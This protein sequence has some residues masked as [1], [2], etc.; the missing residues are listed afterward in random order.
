MQKRTFRLLLLV[1]LL[2]IISCSKDKSTNPSNSEVVVPLTIGNEW[3]YVELD[4]DLNIEEWSKQSVIENRTINLNNQDIDVAVLADYSKDSIYDAW[5]LHNGRNLYKNNSDGLYYYG[6][7]DEGENGTKDSIYFLEETLKVKYPVNVGDSWVWQSGL[8]WT[9]IAVDEEISLPA[10]DFS[11]IVIRAN[12]SHEDEWYI[13]R[14][15]CIN[16]GL[17]ASYYSGVEGVPEG[18][19]KLESYNF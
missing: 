3:I 15:Y 12:I 13:Y 19:T 5:E 7:I 16:V 4:D 2:L 18:W 11:C 1:S 17:V 8:E 10:G 6:F 14:Y 9:C